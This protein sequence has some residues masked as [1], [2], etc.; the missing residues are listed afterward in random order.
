MWAIISAGKSFRFEG[1]D[2][3]EFVRRSVS[4]LLDAG[5]IPV[6]HAD[7]GPLLW[8]EQTQ[9]GNTKEQIADAI[10]AEWLAAGGGDPPWGWLWFVN[11]EVLDSARRPQ[12]KQPI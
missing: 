10:V 3:V 11:R 8:R 6:R 4:R 1:A 7:S 5:G 9:Y 12:S 2:L